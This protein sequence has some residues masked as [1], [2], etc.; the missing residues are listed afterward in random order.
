M[1]TQATTNSVPS[2]FM[3]DKPFF[4]GSQD[5]VGYVRLLTEAANAQQR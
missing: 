1:T 5:P 2:Y 3:D 4:T